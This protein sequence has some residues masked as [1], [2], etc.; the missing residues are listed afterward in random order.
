MGLDGS[1]TVNVDRRACARS[2]ERWF[3]TKYSRDGKES[4]CDGVMTVTDDNDEKIG[5]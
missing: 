2:I 5:T 3:S 4:R 1:Q